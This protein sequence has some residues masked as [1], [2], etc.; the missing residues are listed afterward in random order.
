[1]FCFKSTKS[2]ILP[3][4]FPMA[5]RATVYEFT[6]GKYH[7]LMRDCLK[8]FEHHKLTEKKWPLFQDSIKN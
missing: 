7:I 5:L 8:S 3:Q 2:Q 4:V 6:L 1:M